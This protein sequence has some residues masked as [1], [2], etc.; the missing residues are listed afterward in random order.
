MKK[1]NTVEEIST[2]VLVIQSLFKY[3]HI[4]IFLQEHRKKVMKIRTS[5]TKWRGW[6]FNIP[7]KVLIVI[8]NL[9]KLKVD[10]SDAQKKLQA[11][12][13]VSS[14]SKYFKFFRSSS[15]DIWSHFDSII[16]QSAISIKDFCSLLSIQDFLLLFI[17]TSYTEWAL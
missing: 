1:S 7:V 13:N 4:L 17:E 8:N 10:L 2:N 9:L 12:Q 16:K 15:K 11:L 3:E 6:H 5:P 14:A